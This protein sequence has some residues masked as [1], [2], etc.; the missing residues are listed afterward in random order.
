MDLKVLTNFP[1]FNNA[2][3]SGLTNRIKGCESKGLSNEKIKPPIK[4]NNSLSPKLIRICN[5]RIRV[6]VK[7]SCFKQDKVTF[8]SRNAVNLFIVYELDT[9]SPD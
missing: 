9:W 8:T 1:N 5:S 6:R 4:A 2:R 3:W 7:G